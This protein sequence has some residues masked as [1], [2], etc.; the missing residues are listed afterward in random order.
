MPNLELTLPWAYPFIFQE[1]FFGQP[2][3]FSLLM[4]NTRVELLA[5]GDHPENGK[6]PTL[7]PV[8][9]TGMLGRVGGIA[10]RATSLFNGAGPIDS[11]SPV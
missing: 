6:N 8:S 5:T 9:A 11:I 3:S 10:R 4:P 7:W 2:L 1:V